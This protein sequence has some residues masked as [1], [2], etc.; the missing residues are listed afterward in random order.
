MA[1]KYIAVHILSVGTFAL[2]DIRTMRTWHLCSRLVEEA[3]AASLWFD[4][5][6]IST[7]PP[8]DLE[9]ETNARGIIQSTLAV[10]NLRGY[11]NIAG[12]NLPFLDLL[13]FANDA[14]L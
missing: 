2:T 13:I 4:G 10:Q 11:V 7:I 8:D 1:D 12:T 5:F 3:R 14:D 6:D 9:S